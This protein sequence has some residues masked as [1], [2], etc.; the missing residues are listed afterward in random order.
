VH[1]KCPKCDFENPEDTIY[2]G[3][4]GTLLRSV[5]GTDPTDVGSD[6]RSDRP[7]GDIPDLTKTMEPPTEEFTRGSTFAGRY[8]II[9]RLGKGGM[10]NVYRVEDT[11]LKQEVALKLIKPEI[12][13]DKRIIQRFRNELK[14]AR[15][16]RHKNVCGMYDLGEA[17]GTHFITMEYVRG[18]DLK[19]FIRRS[20][21]LAVGTAVRIAQQVC[22]GLFEAHK[23]GVVHRDLKP[24][25][26]M[27][28]REGSVR[29][30]DFGIARSLRE[31]GITAAGIMVGTPAYMSPEQVEGKEVDQR[32]DIYSLGIILFEMV[33]GRVPSEED[34]PFAAVVKHKG[35]DSIISRCLAKNKEKRYQNAREI[36]SVIKSIE[37]DELLSVKTPEWKN[38]IAVLPFKNMSADPEQ[39][40]F[41]EGMAEEIINALTHIKDLRVV[42]RTSAFS[43]KGKDEDIREIG[44][45][46][47]VDTVLEGSVRKAGNRLR[48]TAQLIDVEDG[49]HLWS[50]KYDRDLED[51]FTIQDEISLAI[52]ENLKLK[53]LEGEKTALLK[54]PTDDAEAYNLY[55]KGLYFA[56]KANLEALQKALEFFREALDMDPGLA[57]AHAGIAMVYGAMSSLDLASPK[58]TMP[59]A[60]AAL[61]KALQL[62]QNLAEAH[63]LTAMIA[64]Y[65]EWDWDAAER[66]FNRT[67]ALNP[68]HSIAHGWNGWFCVA[69]KRFDEAIGEIKLAQK[70]D[71]LMPIFYAFS[72]GIHVAAGKYDEAIDEFRRA[73]ELEPNI[74]LAYFHVGWAYMYKGE[75]DTAV[76]ML[77]KSRELG[78]SPGWA[79]GVIGIIHTKRGETEKAVRI[80]DELVEL[81]KQ[82]YASSWCLGILCAAL[83]DFDRAFE[84]FDKAYEERETLMPFTPIYIDTANPAIKSDPRYKALLKRMKLS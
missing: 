59:K 24:A 7:A 39:E 82:A 52:V 43:F 18:E 1:I 74:G 51:I 15:N 17:E 55:L 25:N 54:R 58:E 75:L 11:K 50:E 61:R 78:V 27:I 44:R 56:L 69:M 62:D 3:K 19:S 6:P 32:S 41:C 70:V 60:K 26:I 36:L 84:F 77:Q 4:C 64:Y 71:P 76:L 57:S 47:S 33:T 21:K 68:G 80:L 30:M 40:Y 29:I 66:S 53:L 73:T 20:G 83:D 16:I 79:E 34:R 13:R 67:F 81:R 63:A 22:E 42:A 38:S 10:G 65:Y 48:I 72:V 45:K 23:L 5:R 2:C 37:V 35:L 14:T 9:E 49:Y 28:D 8:E 12:A 31:E 46:L